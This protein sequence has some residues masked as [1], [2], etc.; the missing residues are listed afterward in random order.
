M[1]KA[2]AAL[3]R[4]LSRYPKVK[5]LLVSAA[6]RLPVID[7]QLRGALERGQHADASLDVDAKQM[8]ESAKLAYKRMRARTP[9]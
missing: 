9:Q 6:Y 4:L 1:K 3:V 2:L 5:R 7:A 8:P